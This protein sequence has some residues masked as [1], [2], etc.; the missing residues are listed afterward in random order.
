VLLLWSGLAKVARPAATAGMLAEVFGRRWP[1][2]R[3]TARLLGLVELA[4]GTAVLVTGSRVACAALALSYL[5]FTGVAVRL[6]S[7]T[8]PAP[9]GCF[10]RSDTPT[11]RVHVVVDALACA[12]GVAATVAP[13]GPWGGF[14]GQPVIVATV[15]IGQV[16]LLAGLA[17]LLIT[18]L[19]SV[20]ADGDRVVGRA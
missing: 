7:R 8:R 17:Y 18:V 19:P 6:A 15:G 4:V 11:G 16:L 1:A 9:C 3:T 13:P 12:V 14:A 2:R 5:V 20:L 10:G